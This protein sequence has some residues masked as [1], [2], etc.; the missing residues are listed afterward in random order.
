MNCPKCGK[1]LIVES[2]GDGK[3]KITCQ[4]CGLAEVI[5][6]QGRKLLTGVQQL[7]ENKNKYL[8]ED[9]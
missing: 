9:R 6:S 2:L 1:A 5:D 8:T 4:S 3:K 7:R